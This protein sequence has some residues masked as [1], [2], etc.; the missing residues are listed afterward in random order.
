MPLCPDDHPRSPRE[1]KPERDGF[2]RVVSAAHIGYGRDGSVRPPRQERRTT[3]TPRRVRAVVW[4][5]SS[6]AS[7]SPPPSEQ[8][9]KPLPLVSVVWNEWPRGRR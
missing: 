2:R 6:D 4:P 1:C 9:V 5:L 8:T 3:I 7:V